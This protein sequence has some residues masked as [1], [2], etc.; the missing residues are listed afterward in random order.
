MYKNLRLTN[1]TKNKSI[2]FVIYIKI[3]REPNIILSNSKLTVHK[4]IILPP[5]NETKG[6]HH[7]HK[8][9]AK[10]VRT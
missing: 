3:S 10:F 9:A 2:F 6:E 7:I 4:V 5:K 1:L 8:N